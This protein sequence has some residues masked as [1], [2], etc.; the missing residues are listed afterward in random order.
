MLTGA[1]IDRVLR[2]GTEYGFAQQ[3][4]R[5][6]DPDGLHVAE[7]CRRG[8]RDRRPARLAVQLRCALRLRFVAV[9]FRHGQGRCKQP[10]QLWA[11]IAG[12]PRCV[13][14]GQTEEAGEAEG[15]DAVILGL[16]GPAVHLGAYVDAQGDLQRRARGRGAGLR[17]RQQLRMQRLLVAQFRGTLPYP[18]RLLEL[19]VARD[20]LRQARELLLPLAPGQFEGGCVHV[21]LV[22]PQ[23]DLPGQ[24]HGDQLRHRVVAAAGEGRLPALVGH[25]GSPAVDVEEQRVEVVLQRFGGYAEGG[26]GVGEQGVG[27]FGQGVELAVQASRAHHDLDAAVVAHVLQPRLVEAAI[28][29]RRQGR[30]G[31]VEAGAELADLVDD[32]VVPA[33]VALEVAQAVHLVAEVAPVGE[34]VLTRE[35]ALEIVRAEPG[36]GFRRSGVEAGARNRARVLLA[37]PAARHV[38]VGVAEEGDAGGHLGQGLVA[39][40][41]PGIHSDELVQ[42]PG[43]GNA[44]AGGRGGIADRVVREDLFG[45][46]AHDSF[47][48]S[49]KAVGLRDAARCGSFAGHRARVTRVAHS[50][51]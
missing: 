36:G 28:G 24:A 8:A 42:G 48:C 29:F 4:Q 13:G 19:A 46:G 50:S 21:V 23:G 39:H 37:E 41:P 47:S 2:V 12:R 26:H 25:P 6:A 44:L 35:P 9:A 10:R 14:D 1:G 22:S 16:E 32:L 11:R 15:L 31:A 34:V 17:D 45:S 51:R 27:G 5:V 30:T 3:R 49:M 20:Q 7:G 43:R 40:L 38:S 18:G 33:H